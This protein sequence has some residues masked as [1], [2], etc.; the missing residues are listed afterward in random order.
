ML[1]AFEVLPSQA[2]IQGQ[3][4]SKLW[5]VRCYSKLQGEATVNGRH[6]EVW[7]SLVVSEVVFGQGGVC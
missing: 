6:E 5:T 7:Q 1:P 3:E 2:L 4:V